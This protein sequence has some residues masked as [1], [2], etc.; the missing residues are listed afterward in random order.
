MDS[1]GKMKIGIEEQTTQALENIKAILKEEQLTLKN[2]VKVT[3]FLSDITDFQSVNEIYAAYFQDPYPARSA[4]AV[5]ALP[6]GGLVEIEV[7]ARK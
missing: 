1:T 5:A 6:L 4:F 3:I 7:L 2:I